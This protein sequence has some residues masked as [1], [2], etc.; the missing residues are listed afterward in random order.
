[1]Q[2][3][4]IHNKGLIIWIAQEKAISYPAWPSGNIGR[5]SKRKNGIMSFEDLT[6]EQKAKAMACKTP[7]DLRALADKEGYALSDEELESIVG[8]ITFLGC[9]LVSKSTSHSKGK[10]S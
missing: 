6:E 1:M 2:D 3:A 5:G 8:G 9:P 4:R 7:E 10:L